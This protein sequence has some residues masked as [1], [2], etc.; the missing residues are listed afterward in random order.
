MK[1]KARIYLCKYDSLSSRYASQQRNG[2]LVRVYGTTIRFVLVVEHAHNILHY[3]RI[4]L[5]TSTKFLIKLNQIKLNQRI[6]RTLLTKKLSFDR[7]K[8]ENKI[9]FCSYLGQLTDQNL[10]KNS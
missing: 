6:E 10:I 4:D 3:D 9:K 7:K 1:H 2:A 8:I 5:S